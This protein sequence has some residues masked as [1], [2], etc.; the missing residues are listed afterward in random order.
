MTLRDEILREGVGYTGNSFEENFFF[1][2][3]AKGFV[4]DYRMFGEDTVELYNDVYGEEYSEIF[5]SFEENIDTL[6]EEVDSDLML[7][8]EQ[9]LP[10]PELYND[11]MDNLKNL[12]K[13]EPSFS[14]KLK[15][16]YT[17]FE[18]DA[19]KATKELGKDIE[20]TGKEVSSTAKGILKNV[21]DKAEDIG[22]KAKQ[23]YQ[24][25]ERSAKETATHVKGNVAATAVAARGVLGKVW[26]KIKEFGKGLADKYPKVADF[27][28]KGIG[29]IVANPLVVAGAAGGTILL[30]SLVKALKK[31]G[32]AK[33]A[34]K[35]QKVIDEAKEKKAEVEGE[36]KAASVDTTEKKSKSLDTTGRAMKS[37]DTT[38]RAMKSLDTSKKHKKC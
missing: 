12:K 25:I 16:G 31:R 19:K 35:L 38:G 24:N 36:K 8:F 6:M 2:K 10:R 1:T 5:E 29:W 33:K 21:S 9:D 37:L 28:G 32:D 30:A 17:H 4:N 14:E 34:A 15:K 11:F 26:D 20:K 27:I 23:D 7:L 3:L 18:K 22:D 13:K